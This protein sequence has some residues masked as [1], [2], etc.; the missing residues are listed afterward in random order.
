MCD[1]F[2]FSLN[3]VLGVWTGAMSTLVH[4]SGVDFG[5]GFSPML[6]YGD[7]CVLLSVIDASQSTC[8]KRSNRR[9]CRSRLHRMELFSVHG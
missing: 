1:V 8:G 5:L 7:R 4:R 3:W 9:S 6:S 2:D